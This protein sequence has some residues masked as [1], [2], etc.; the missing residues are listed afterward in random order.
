VTRHFGGRVKGAV[1]EFEWR[2]RPEVPPAAA[3]AAAAAAAEGG[4]GDSGPAAV[5]GSESGA[6]A[7]K[8]AGLPKSGRQA[9]FSRFPEY[10]HDPEEPKAAATPRSGG[11]AW[12][13]GGGVRTDATRSIVRMN[14]RG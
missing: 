10:L 1:G 11:G 7:F 2:P 4:G 12:R 5:S 3:L 9:T 8:P 6:A 13:P 14:L